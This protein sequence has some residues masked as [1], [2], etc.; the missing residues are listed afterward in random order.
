MRSERGFTLIELIIYSMLSIVVLLIVG[1][2]LI[3]SLRAENTVRAATEAT[4]SGQLVSQ[5]VGRGIRNASAIQ[6]TEPWTDAVLLTA[7]TSNSAAAAGWVCQAWAYSAGQIRTKTST[8]AIPT[9]TAS[10]VK[11]WTLLSDGVAPVPGTPVFAVTDRS[12][13]LAF[14]SATGTGKP[15]LIQTSALSRQ[16]VPATGVESAPCF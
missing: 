4:T 3:N 14:E 5:S 7:R 9:P 10:T 2:F 15:V 11:T 16:P 1:G 12:V 6:R 13:D 8:T